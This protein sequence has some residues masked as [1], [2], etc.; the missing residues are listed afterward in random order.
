MATVS[1]PE[2][3]PLAR[4]YHGAAADSRHRLCVWGGNN[5]VE[6]STLERFDVSSATWE[7]SPGK[8]RDS[9]GFPCLPDGLQRMAVA[10]SGAGKAYIFGGQISEDEK[11]LNDLYE[12]DLATSECR[13]LIPA[14]GSRKPPGP[15]K[16]SAM[17]LY[18]GK[19]VVH[20]GHMDQNHFPSE[21]HVFDLE[22]CEKPIVAK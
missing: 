15:R 22:K 16:G 9:L 18:E 19:L 6:T 12:I 21:L 5:D 8:L 14:S 10:S 2:A 7:S 13:V 4:A 20:G 11:F 1:P 3:E 17:V